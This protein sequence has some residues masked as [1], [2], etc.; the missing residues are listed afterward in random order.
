MRK[1]GGFAFLAMIAVFMGICAPQAFA[2]PSFE[3]AFG[4]GVTGSP[5]F[6]NCT[7]ATGC[8]T[9]DGIGTAG[10]MHQPG[11]A[12]FDTHGGLLVADFSNRRI[13][14]YLVDAD[15][16]ASFDRTFGYGVQAAVP[17]SFQ[18]CTSS[19]EAGG[20]SG[21]PPLPAPPDRWQCVP[22]CA[23]LPTVAQ[24]STIVPSPT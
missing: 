1:S 7:A 16:S 17:D 22:I 5:G 19:G 14:R 21:T 3:R 15:G 12:V 11:G 13:D 10:S 18:T 2:A 6:G 23:Q 8:V 4:G 24:V 9:G 20:G